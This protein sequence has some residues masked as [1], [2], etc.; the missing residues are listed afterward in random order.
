MQMVSPTPDHQGNYNHLFNATP[1]PDGQNMFS[2]QN[3]F[4]P[5]TTTNRS[6]KPTNV[7]D[8]SNFMGFPMN[9]NT[10]QQNQWNIQP[11]GQQQQQQQATSRLNDLSNSTN[12][13]QPHMEGL[14]AVTNNNNNNIPS[15]LM[16]NSTTTTSV[17]ASIATSSVS[18][19]NN[20]NIVPNNSNN[21]NQNNVG[22]G[23]TSNSITNYMIDIDSSDLA[24]LNTGDL[25]PDGHQHH[26]MDPDQD[27]MTDS[28]TRLRLE[29]INEFERNMEG[30]VSWLACLIGDKKD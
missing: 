28:L 9:T 14:M 10:Q 5:N 25:L 8:N 1:T 7:V 17:T 22:G 29:V 4:Q 13:F 6:L 2:A 24:Q 20:M 18:P 26:R 19:Y 15:P 12:P 21:Q 27:N 11:S 3:P 16:A 30:D 23:G